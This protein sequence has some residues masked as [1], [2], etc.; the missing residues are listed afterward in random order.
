MQDLQRPHKD[1]LSDSTKLDDSTWS[2]VKAAAMLDD[3]QEQVWYK[4]LSDEDKINLEDL[5]IAQVKQG[6]MLPLQWQAHNILKGSDLYFFSEEKQILEHQENFPPDR[7]L[8][9]RE[10]PPVD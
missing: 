8:K 1:I 4:S 3:Y 5:R 9:L 10:T 7:I 2:Q 6:D